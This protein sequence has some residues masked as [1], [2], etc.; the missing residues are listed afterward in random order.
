MPDTAL[1][2]GGALVHTTNVLCPHGTS[3]LGERDEEPSKQTN[4]YITTNCDACCE[5]K[6]YSKQWSRWLASQREDI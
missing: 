2:A 6:E 1:G 5:G 3:S 4:K